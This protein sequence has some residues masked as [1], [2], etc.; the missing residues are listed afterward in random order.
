MRF[1]DTNILLY[2]VSTDPAEAGKAAAAA[3][4]LGAED[5]CLSVQV[6]QEF[7]VQ[8]TRA[9]RSEPLRHDDAVAFIDTWHRFPVQE[10]SI[11]LLR[12]AF[13]ATKR[14]G[15]SYWDA[16]IIEAARVL[17]C[18]QLLTEDLN[19]GQ[20]FDGVTVVN[21]FQALRSQV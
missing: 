7:Y 13:A 17:A 16:A 3:E 1:V 18:D 5:L 10:V 15:V 14:W 11:A 4:L 19:A 6:L 8:A 20:V 9:T 12:A 2:S 21:P